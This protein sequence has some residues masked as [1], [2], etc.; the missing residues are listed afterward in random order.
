M[1]TSAIIMTSSLHWVNARRPNLLEEGFISLPLLTNQVNFIVG[2]AVTL[3]KFGRVG[4]T[5]LVCGGTV[6][7]FAVVVVVIVGVG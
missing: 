4:G 6:V 1:T 2:V 7:V 3:K 5:S